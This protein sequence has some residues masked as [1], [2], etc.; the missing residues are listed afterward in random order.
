MNKPIQYAAFMEPANVKLGQRYTFE[1]GERA[2]K[3]RLTAGIFTL[4]DFVFFQLALAQQD[5]ET[6]EDIDNPEANDPYT[7]GVGGFVS[8]GGDAPLTEWDLAIGA[9]PDIF[10]NADYVSTTGF[11]LFADLDLQ[12]DPLDDVGAYIRTRLSTYT[13]TS[14][15]VWTMVVN[16]GVALKLF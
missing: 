16:Y 6:F 8:I 4:F 13:H 12:I 14:P 2:Q 5:P 1:V 9:G 15:I 3:L 7:V 10:S 11:V